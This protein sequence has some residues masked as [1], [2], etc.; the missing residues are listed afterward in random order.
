MKLLKSIL[1]LL[2]VAMMLTSCVKDE[3]Y[4]YTAKVAILTTSA[5]AEKEC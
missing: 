3:Y 4:Q 5:D 2:G 1:L